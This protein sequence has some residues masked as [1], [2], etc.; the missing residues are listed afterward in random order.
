CSPEDVAAWPD[1]RLAEFFGAA[2]FS[3]RVGFAK[4][5]PDIYLSACRQL[6]VDPAD[7][8]FIGDGGS[9]ELRG[10]ESA[11]FT[12]Y[13]AAW[14]LRDWPSWK[15]RGKNPQGRYPVLGSIDEVLLVIDQARHQ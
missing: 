15:K 7:C 3:F 1:C 10:A 12:V 13:Q 4:P 6:E 11:G 5:H 9:D 2:V 14:Y 8:L